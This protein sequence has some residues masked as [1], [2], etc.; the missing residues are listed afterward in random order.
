[1]NARRHRQAVA[2]IKADE[3]IKEDDKRRLLALPPLYLLA[4]CRM[5][6]YLKERES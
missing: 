4:W 6:H 3:R 1:M 5:A 2:R